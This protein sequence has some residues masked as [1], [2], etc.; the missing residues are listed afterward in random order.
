MDP[1]LKCSKSLHSF[2]VRSLI[3]SVK[4]SESA[5]KKRIVGSIRKLLVTPVID[6][7]IH[8]FQL[9]D[10]KVYRLGLRSVRSTATTARSLGHLGPDC[11]SSIG[12][13]FRVGVGEDSV[14]SQ[15]GLCAFVVRDRSVLGLAT[16]GFGSSRSCSVGRVCI[17]IA[18]GVALV[19]VVGSV[20]VLG[21]F[22]TLVLAWQRDV[23]GSKPRPGKFD[24]NRN[25]M[26]SMV[27]EEHHAL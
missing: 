8:E 2:T 25:V 10:T 20:G 17:G 6:N 16:G 9:T 3:M 24:L 23:Y 4:R 19:L 14:L 7:P 12:G 22:D 13:V 5:K 21:T 1:E 11:L 18:R 27:V 15:W 26:N